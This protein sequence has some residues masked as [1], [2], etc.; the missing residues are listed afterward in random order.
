MGARVAQDDPKISAD[1][2]EFMDSPPKTLIAALEAIRDVAANALN[3][4]GPPQDEHS[5]RWKCKDCQYI[6][7]FTRPVVLETAGRCPRCKSTKFRPIL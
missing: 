5:M 3:R 7:R 6:K 1:G 2:I 4:I